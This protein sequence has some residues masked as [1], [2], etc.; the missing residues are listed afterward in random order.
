MVA[1]EEP[2]TG[3]SNAAFHEALADTVFAQ[4]GKA[5]LRVGGER[6]GQNHAQQQD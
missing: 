2:A 3:Q 5:L 6:Y 1:A 4:Q